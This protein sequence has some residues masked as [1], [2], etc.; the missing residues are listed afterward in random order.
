MIIEQIP[1]DKRLSLQLALDKYTKSYIRRGVSFV[2][3]AESEYVGNILI[4]IT[5]KK[6]TV[7]KNITIVYNQLTTD[8]EGFSEGYIFKMLSLSEIGIII[9]SKV[10]SLTTIL[11]KI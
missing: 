7:Q 3:S 4:L 10:Q 8:W 6:G 1:N 5:G 11:S 2:I 9:K